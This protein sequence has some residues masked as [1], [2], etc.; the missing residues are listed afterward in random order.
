MGG[1][2]LEYGRLFGELRVPDGTDEARSV[3]SPAAYFVELLGLL[4]GTFD[5]PALLE[6]RPDLK[7]IVLDTEN[8]F[9]E[10]AYLDIVNEVRNGS[11]APGRTR[12]CGPAR[13]RWGCRSQ[14]TPGGCG[15][16]STSCG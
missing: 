16:R 5:Q 10:T 4:E 11:S 2:S 13:T 1:S 3:C 14:S 12:R 15:R 7:Q 8:T 6:R 9:T